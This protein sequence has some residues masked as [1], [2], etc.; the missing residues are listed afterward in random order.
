MRRG[1]ID[2]RNVK[3]VELDGRSFQSKGE[4]QGYLWLKADEQAGN[5]SNIRCQTQVALLDGPQ[6]MRVIYR[7]DFVVFD[8]KLQCDVWIEIKGFETDVWKI[9][10]KLWRHFGPGRLRIY[11][12]GWGKLVFDEEVI[13]KI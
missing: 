11:K 2:Y 10:L 7:P 4:A 1:L 13:P 12:V 9:K 3:R 6:N 5:I 8:H